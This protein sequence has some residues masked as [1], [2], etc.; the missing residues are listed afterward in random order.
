MEWIQK[1][2]DSMSVEELEFT[3]RCLERQIN[4]VMNTTENERELNDLEIQYELVCECL[5]IL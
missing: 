3:K 5:G 4:Y 1:D 2:F